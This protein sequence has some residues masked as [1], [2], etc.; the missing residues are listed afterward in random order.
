MKETTNKY[1]EADYVIDRIAEKIVE[2]YR[3]LAEEVH[4]KGVAVPYALDRLNRLN[5]LIDEHKD[6]PTRMLEEKRRLERTLGI[7]N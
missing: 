2:T 7:E 3:T 1:L 5:T 6:P 4:Q